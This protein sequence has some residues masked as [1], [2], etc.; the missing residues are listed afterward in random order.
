MLVSVDRGRYIHN[1]FNEF[2]FFDL[3]ARLVAALKLW[4]SHR[5][6]SGQGWYVIFS[7]AHKI[8]HWFTPYILSDIAP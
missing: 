1:A 2:G 7:V 8:A 5:I 4:A 6:A 3:W